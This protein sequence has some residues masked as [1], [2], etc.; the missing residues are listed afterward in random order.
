MSHKL[1]LGM[2]FLNQMV[3]VYCE[4]IHCLFYIKCFIY[5]TRFGNFSFNS[6]EVGVVDRGLTKFQDCR[7]FMRGNPASKTFQSHS[8]LLSRQL[9]IN[10]F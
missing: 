8:D 2:K 6:Y 7:F 10:H 4:N 5:F 3:S 1:I 9:D